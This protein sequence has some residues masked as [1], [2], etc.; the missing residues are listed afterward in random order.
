MSVDFDSPCT[1]HSFHEV[2]ALM[3]CDES[4]DMDTRALYASNYYKRGRTVGTVVELAQNHAKD[5]LEKRNAGNPCPDDRAALYQIAEQVEQDYIA[6]AERE[7]T[8]AADRLRGDSPEVA[9]R[10]AELEVEFHKKVEKAAESRKYR[11]NKA[12]EMVQRK[13]TQARSS[14]AGTR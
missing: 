10:Q 11:E 13:L 4:F 9:E 3:E 14:L 7:Y 2:A 6:A 5:R 12:D 8:A 1:S